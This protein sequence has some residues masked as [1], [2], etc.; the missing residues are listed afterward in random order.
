MSKKSSS[1]NLWLLNRKSDIY[2]SD[3]KKK[4]YRARSAYKLLE[5]D[6]KFNIIEKAKNIVDLGA[7]PGSWSQVLIEKNK[8]N[9]KIKIFAI[10]LKSIKPLQ[11]VTMVKNDIA[12]IIETNIYFEKNNFDLV[13]SDMAPQSTGHRFTDQ[14]KASNLSELALS[15]AIKYLSING[16]FV[17]KLLG[18][19]H[20]NSLIN[21]AKKKFNVVHL[22]K[23]KSSKVASKEIYLISKGFNNLQ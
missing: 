14:V 7:A 2:F 23:P 18:G 21:Q 17:C 5:I 6:K 13:L 9:S 15:F 22:F 16:S 8:S 11:N 10:D 12:D 1:Q 20:D 4:G 3:A 19:H